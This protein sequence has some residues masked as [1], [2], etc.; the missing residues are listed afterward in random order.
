VQSLGCVAA[1]GADQYQGERATGP[2]ELFGGTVYLSTGIPATAGTNQ[3]TQANHRIWAMDYVKSEDERLGV[4]S[5]N[6]MSGP[7][8]RWPATTAQQPPPKSTTVAAGLVYGVAIEQ[9]PSCSTEIATPTDD[10]YLAYGTYTST[11]TVTPGNFFLVYQVGGVSGNTSGDV[12]TNK[13]A[14]QPPPSTVTI[15]SWAPLFE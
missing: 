13:V 3:C 6:P 12:T 2:M 14:L 7:A 8:G 1:C 4:A 5:P 10:P 9:Q 15:D 11:S